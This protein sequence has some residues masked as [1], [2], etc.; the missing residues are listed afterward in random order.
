MEHWPLTARSSDLE[1]QDSEES[2]IS[3]PDGAQGRPIG[4]NLYALLISEVTQDYVRFWK[5]TNSPRVRLCRIAYSVSLI[6][7]VLLLQ[8]FLLYAIF[9]FLCEPSVKHI[10]LLYSK[11]EKTMYGD[12]ALQSGGFWRGAEHAQINETAFTALSP[13]D[14]F[15]LCNF[16]LSQPVFTGA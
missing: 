8:I 9:V 7:A 4:R 5:G 11:Y 12:Q 14:Q 3:V 16:P 1:D 2:Q 13:D 6:L 15:K 10:R